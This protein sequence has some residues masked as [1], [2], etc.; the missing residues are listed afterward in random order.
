MSSLFDDSFLAS[1]QTPRG[2]EEE[3]PPPPEDEHGPEP[4]PP[5]LFGGQFCRPPD[6]GARYRAG[7]PPPPPDPP[8]PLEG[9]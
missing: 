8:A 2:H 3:P 7:R 6:R 5:A 1:L 9:R 4:V